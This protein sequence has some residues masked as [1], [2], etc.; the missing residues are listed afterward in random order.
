MPHLVRIVCQW[1]AR[2][3]PQVHQLVIRHSRARR[4]AGTGLKLSLPRSFASQHAGSRAGRQVAAAAA[5]STAAAAGVEAAAVKA[6]AQVQHTRH[7]PQSRQR[8]YIRERKAWV[9]LGG[10][11]WVS[12][13]LWTDGVIVPE[14]LLLQP[15]HHHPVLPLFPLQ[16][17]S[18]WRYTEN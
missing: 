12:V 6:A 14:A 2:C 17:S 8:R 9:G 5:A 4:R 16:L 18:R 3:T 15:C 10:S 7:V 11:W 1:R 13:V